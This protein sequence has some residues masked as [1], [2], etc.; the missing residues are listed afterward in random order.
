MR[1]SLLWISVLAISISIVLSFSFAGCKT[2]TKEA[3][4][5]E[6]EVEEEVAEEAPAEEVAVEEGGTLSILCFQGYAEDD[7]VKPF[8]EKYNCKVEVTY[9]GT[10]EEHF[11]KT[12]FY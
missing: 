9:A 6:E 8:E 4:P 1:K 10:V 5:V 2:P 3:A 11:K 7:W 12:Q